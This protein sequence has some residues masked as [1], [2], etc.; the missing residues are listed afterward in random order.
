MGFCRRGRPC[1]MRPGKSLPLISTD[2]RF[3]TRY[4]AARAAVVR[5]AIRGTIVRCGFQVLDKEM[6]NETK[7]TRYRQA[8]SIT[9]VAI[10]L[11]GP[12]EVRIEMLV[13]LVQSESLEVVA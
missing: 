11:V 4:A 10:V 6:H 8:P 2:P 13:E 7:T 1:P 3:R 12:S 5:V 9:P